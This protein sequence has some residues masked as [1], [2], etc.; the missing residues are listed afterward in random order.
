M[1][2][3]QVRMQLDTNVIRIGE[4]TRLTITAFRD[5]R[6]GTQA[7]GWPQWG[8]TLNGGLE[9]VKSLGQDTAVAETMDG[10]SFIAVSQSFLVTSWDSGF[11]TV[12][13]LYVSIGADSIASNSLILE[14]LMPPSGEAGKIAAPADIRETQWTWTERLR[15]WLPW[16]GGLLALIA[17]LYGAYRLWRNRETHDDNIA[18]EAPVPLEPAHVI[19]LRELERIQRNA[20][21]KEGEFKRHHSETSTALRTYLENR[22]DFPALER[23]SSEIGQALAHLPLT[24]EDKEILTEVLHV[25]DLVKFAKWNPQVG[26]HERMVSRA[27]KFV[28]RTLPTS[29]EG[30]ESTAP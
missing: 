1:A 28:E 5:V 25:T 12:P 3:Q 13:P 19:A 11:V 4:Q 21:W 29:P 18:P 6:N 23:T 16:A 10:K 2:G 26:D 30:A 20:I 17:L 8:D 27:L 14:V 22:F 15:R 9:L 7:I 24:H